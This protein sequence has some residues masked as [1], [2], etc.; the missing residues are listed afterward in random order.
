M[1]AA[2]MRWGPRTRIGL[3][4]APDGVT[5][6]R[7]RGRGRRRIVTDVRTQP[8]PPGVVIVSPIEPNIADPA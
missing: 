1:S 3:E 2:A 7:T 4:I 6:V 5:L 8:L